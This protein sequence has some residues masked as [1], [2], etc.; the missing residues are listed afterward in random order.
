MELR[1]IMGLEGA[2]N[3]VVSVGFGASDL[4][5]SVQVRNNHIL[6]EKPVL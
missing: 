2:Y 1:G 4:T 5:L 3:I 6:T